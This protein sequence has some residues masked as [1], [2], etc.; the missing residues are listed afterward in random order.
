MAPNTLVP[1]TFY[2]DIQQR[3]LKEIDNSPY[4]TFNF[5][6]ATPPSVADLGLNA[7]SEFLAFPK[8]SPQIVKKLSSDAAMRFRALKTQP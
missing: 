1:R 3:V 6:L 2:S 7:F 4:F 5:D 8:A